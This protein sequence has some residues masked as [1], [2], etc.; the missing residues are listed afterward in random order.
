[1][2]MKKRDVK[3]LEKEES[4]FDLSDH[5]LHNERKIHSRS[6]VI[7]SKKR[8]FLKVLQIGYKAVKLDEKAQAV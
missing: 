8:S 1:M 3:A 2:N 6:T 5:L 4:K 7:Q